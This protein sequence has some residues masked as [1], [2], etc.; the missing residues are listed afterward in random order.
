[1]IECKTKISPKS[2][3]IIKYM[4]TRTLEHNNIR[5]EVKGGKDMG[6]IIRW[7][8]M[9]IAV[10]FVSCMVTRSWADFYPG[11]ADNIYRDYTKIAQL[12]VCGNPVTASWF[13]KS[14]GGQCDPTPPSNAPVPYTLTGVDIANATK[15]EV[16][17]T[18]WGGHNKVT[19]HKFNVNGGTQFYYMPQL[20]GTPTASSNYLKFQYSAAPTAI[21]ISTLVSGNNTIGV[22]AETQPDGVPFY[23]VYSVTVR[24]YYDSSKLHPTGTI[25]V[26]PG[27]DSQTF[28]ANVPAYTGGIRQ[29]DY[30]G[31]YKDYNWEGDGRFQNWHHTYKNGI[32]DKHIGT[33]SGT[34]YSATWDTRWVPDQDQ[35]MK[36]VARIV[37]NDGMCYITDAVN[38]NFSRNYSIKLISSIDVPQGF[39]V[40]SYGPVTSYC[41]Y[42]IDTMTNATAAK[43]IIHTFAGSGECWNNTADDA[44]IRELGIN[45]TVLAGTPGTGTPAS[46]PIGI[47]L[48]NGGNAF[49]TYDI[50]NL[51]YLHSGSNEFFIRCNTAHHWLEVTW[52]GPALLVKYNT[53]G[54]PTAS[55]TSP[56]NSA[57]F[58][59]PANI[60]I[61]ATATDSDGTITKVEFYQGTTKLGEDTVSPYSYAWSNVP[62][63]SYTLTVKATDNSGNITTSN[64]VSIT[65]SGGS[66]VGGWWD[67]NWNYRVGLD[68]QAGAYTR[69]NKPVE[70][71][72]NFT[73]LVT[74]LGG[75]GAFDPGSIRVVEVL[76]DGTVVNANVPFQF[77]QSSTYNATTNASGTLVFIMDN[78]TVANATRYYHVY[79]NTG[80]SMTAP[81]VTPQVTLTDNVMVEGQSSY[82][83]D[84]A[85]A[86]Y[87]YHKIGGG[88][89]SIIDKQNNDWISYKQTPHNSSG[90]SFRGIPNLGVCGHPGYTADAYDP[91]TVLGA[92]STIVSQGPLKTT[93]H[94][95]TTDNNW[96]WTWDFYPTYAKMTLL[97]RDP[98][99]SYWFLYEG[100]PGGSFV[101]GS[102]YY[103]RSSDTSQQSGSTAFGADIPSPEWI[104][105]ADG[106]INR[107]LFLVNNT[108]DSLTDSHH[109]MTDSGG[110]MTV[111][112]FGRGT[113]ADPSSTA[114]WLTACPAYFT[115]GLAD[116]RD[117]ATTSKTIESA[118]RDLGI[119]QRTA[120]KKDGSITPPPPSLTLS[121]KEVTL[122]AAG[123]LYGRA[124]GDIDGD[125][126][127]EV[128]ANDWASYSLGSHGLVYFDYPDAT[129]KTLISFSGYPDY[130]YWRSDDIRLADMNKDGKL[131]VIGGISATY[132]DNNN[133]M[134]ELWE[135]MGGGVWT[136]H[137]LDTAANTYYIKNIVIADIDRDG[138]LDV[139]IRTDPYSSSLSANI[140][141]YFQDTLNSWVKKSFNTV[142]DEGM[143]VGDID[144]DGYPD[145]AIGGRWYKTPATGQRTGTY[146]AYDFASKWLPTSPEQSGFPSWAQGGCRVKIADLND[147]G[148]NEILVSPAEAPTKTLPVAYYTSNNPTGGVSAWTEHVLEANI[149][150]A[151]T[152]EVADFDKNGKLDVL[153]GGIGLNNFG[154]NADKGL[155][156]YLQSPDGTFTRSNITQATKG[157]YCAIIGD[158]NNDGDIDIANVSSFTNGPSTVYE[159]L[160]SA[161]SLDKWTYKQIDN[162]REVYRTT[163]WTVAFFGITA[164]DLTGHN[165]GYK[166][167]V[168]GKYFYR[169][170]GGDMTGTWNRTTF[171]VNCDGILAV[172][173]DSDAYA[174]V[175]AEMLPDVYWLEATSPDGSS[176][177]VR[178][179]I[180]QV[181]ATVHGLGQ[182][183]ALAQ[184][185]PGGKP[186]IVITG[187]STGSET[188][189]FQ[190]P[191]TNPEAGNWPRTLVTSAGS[192]EMIGV[193]DI[194]KDGNLDI[195]AADRSTPYQVAWW[196]NP[197]VA[198][199]ANWTKYVIGT[200]N[201]G[202]ASGFPNCARLADINGD[203][204]LDLVISAEDYLST[205]PNSPSYWYECPANPTANNWICHT[206][207]MGSALNS[208]DVADVDKDGDIDVM[209]GEM[210][211]NKRLW[212]Y[213]NNGQGTLTSHLVASGYE[214]NGA[215][216]L[217]LDGDGD[218]DIVS[219]T[220]DAPQYLH[221][222]RN[223]AVGT[224][225]PVNTPPTVNISAIDV[226]NGNIAPATLTIKVNASDTDGIKQV[227]FYSNSNW[228]G[229]DTSSPYEFAW[230]VNNPGDYSIQ[231][232]A[233]DNG[234]PNATAMSAAQVVTITGVTPP[235][236]QQAYPAGVAWLV[237]TGTTTIQSEDYDMV[238]NGVAEGEAYHDTTT[239]NKGGGYRTAEGVDVRA[240]TSDAGGGYQVGWTV[241]GEWLEY[242]INVNQAGNYKIILRGAN[243][244]TSDGGPMHIEFVQ[245]NATYVQTTPSVGTPPTGSYETFTDV[246]LSA[247]VTLNAGNQI[248]KLVMDNSSA[249]GNGD[250][251]YIQLVLVS[252]ETPNTV[253]T[254][255]ISPA[256]GT[257]SGSVSV[258]LTCATGGAEIR[259]TT[260]GTDPTSSSTLYSAPF[261][262]TANATVKACAFKTAMTDSSINSVAYIITNTSTQQAYPAGVAWLVGTGSTTIQV[263]DYDMVTSGSGE[264]VAY[265]DTTPGQ[266]DASNTYRPTEGVD[267]EACT[268]IG[269]GYDIGYT[270]VGEWLEYSVNVNQS[271]K[272]KI[273]LRTA[274]GT[275][276]DDMVHLSFIQNSATY[277]VTPSVS[278]P[279]TGGWQVWV[280]TEVATDVTLNAGNQIM[281]LELD[282]SA[283][284]YCSNFNYIKLIRTS[285]ETINTVE[286]PTI[287]PSAGTYSN[288][289]TVT[290]G[291]ATSGAEIRYTTNG[292]DPTSSSTLYSAPFTLTASATVRARAFKAAMTDSSVNSV[293][294]TV[295]IASPQQ[296]YGNNGNPWQIITGTTTIEVENFDTVTSGIAEGEA[297]HDMDATNR[298]GAYRTTD[299][300]DIEAV[301]GASNGYDIGYVVPGEWLEYS[302]NVNQDGDYKII[303]SAGNGGTTASP[304]HVEFGP[305]NA[306]N[307]VTPSVSIPNTGGWTTFTDIT[308][309]N[310]VTLAA[311]NQIM[312]L[313][314]ETGSASNNGNFDYIKLIR[315]TPD[316]TPPVVSAVVSANITGSGLVITWTTN[317]PANSKIE[318]GLTT[319]YGSAT[320]ITDTTGVYTH[321][322]TLS[323]LTE[324]TAY[325]YRMVSVDMNGNTTMTGDYSFTTTAYDTTAPVISNVSA[326]VTQNSAVIKWNTDENSDSQVGYGTTTLMGTATTLDA[327][328]TR[329]HSVSLSGLQKG[330]TYYYK[331][332]SKDATGNLATSSQYSFKTYNLKHKIYTYYYDDGT[333]TTKVGATPAVSLK[334][335]VQVYNV[336]ENS[337]ATDYT[338]T[339]TLTTKNSKGTELD[340]TDSTL[341]TADAGEKEVAIPFRSDINT[342]EL[343]GDTTAPVVIGFNDMY[344][345]KLVGYQGG[346]IR[347]ANGLKILIPTGVLSANK[348]L[349]SIKTSAAPE[350]KNTMKYVNTL[351]PICYDFGELTFNNNA[352]V[353]ENQTFT[354]AV[355]ITIPY[356]AADIGTLNEDGLRIY[357]W[358]GTDWELVSG[359]QTV[360]KSNNTITA[361]VKHFS[362]YRILGSYVSADMSNV[363]VYPNPYNPDTAVL[364]KLKIINLPMNS[365]MKLYSVDGELIRELKELDFGNLGWLEWDGK[366][367]DGDKVARAVY[368]YHIEDA[369]GN[370]KTG[371]IGL[372]R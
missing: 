267:V 247:G 172:D 271:G 219:P 158:L 209:V 345:A 38:L 326:G 187:G 203:G 45:G 42:N 91:T 117:Y 111:F 314:M 335:K 54:M 173:V 24:V 101:A 328:S 157:A 305:H 35:P 282:S 58:S 193:G 6:K 61:N 106:T 315:Q 368:I 283:A 291:C 165:N 97:K 278:L 84:T 169:N 274:R 262:L 132:G 227:D 332:Y 340:T 121:F 349:A 318:Y 183:A 94:S 234:T 294:Y 363:K 364:G 174:D 70:K 226:T 2:K 198:G 344:I 34:S 131:D 347:G 272:Y 103:Y 29:V 242:S 168:S 225:T 140:C 289:V 323:G 358:T 150:N 201:V 353:L 71:D 76:G 236:T 249:V 28:T 299:G 10:T 298:G 128:V 40:A 53:V 366:N 342:V 120:E 73:T 248:M 301:T 370:K 143:D 149:Q 43:L 313:V 288:S 74:G 1:M 112:G 88:F 312:K 217:D 260:N 322:V 127:S 179:T 65:V 336:D 317:E 129:E 39:G 153:C 49:N 245:N 109:A 93:I 324:K 307:I 186:E 155:W 85:N 196:K 235:A 223:D 176:W 171:P 18:F 142:I 52:P 269:V 9:L 311:G 138:K 167:I 207:A 100:T 44:T 221:M 46:I 80:T 8:M 72:I 216:M 15:A 3:K 114:N 4:N 130:T 348:Y 251:N 238:T 188:Y 118:W 50:T 330:K 156:V 113:T 119:V 275:T 110:S 197:G 62:G 215:K 355:N 329:L 86:T 310:S 14:N 240:I 124:I 252:A 268:D 56:S 147:D 259:Y 365:V 281:R 162:S 122:N 105:F 230:T 69:T 297:Y 224:G 334:F 12:G 206:I 136:R 266:E 31:N 279:G 232:K 98:A 19:G 32:L 237:G 148:K 346:S 325:H 319:S 146:T 304:F 239:S 253:A 25:S 89:A 139:V 285:A 338:G 241:P 37:G 302:V 185:I 16:Y 343:S 264:G 357:Y 135:N 36:A 115:I 350:V 66:T 369:A 7:G 77:N 306:T 243:G 222:W 95:I 220:F 116:S 362:T 256:A 178:A 270:I 367:G 154:D 273:V 30:I 102:D 145:I 292:T 133:C 286:T 308:V 184:I 22:T 284:T 182:G 208:L 254:P 204:R 26:T 126:K 82:K 79:F 92:N 141:I 177:V 331:V 33:G 210:K 361:T 189:Y 371:K 78:T 159:N 181:P 104:Y 57:T 13:F 213:E 87:M 75:S 21:P 152:L 246:T 151:H 163:P 276:V 229:T 212:I 290:L 351:N 55:I 202:P 218:L 263:E 81:T 125:G 63:G 354:R 214:T 107:S 64:P 194:D 316:T 96:E 23:W 59:A 180:G 295:T 320:V 48:A 303:V 108:D 99:K 321:S 144:G 309:A 280:D 192:D 205:G 258:T 228:I 175:I 83:L 211:T 337:I 293:A 333:T 191:T 164:A 261:T 161:F 327:T 341:V 166:D 257:Y 339:L 287:S 356:T 51:S 20:T 68:I 90:G 277:L 160:A 5:T 199:Q 67:T 233:T 17:V 255:T 300:V 60:T 231:A 11:T 27:A 244:E 359:V 47:S 123:Y 296:S 134:V 190:I 265:H 137:N 372:I 170:P 352:P 195:A 250:I 200:I 41:H 360:D